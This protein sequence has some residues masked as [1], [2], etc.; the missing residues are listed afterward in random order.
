[1]APLTLAIM[2]PSRLT[3]HHAILSICMSGLC[4]VN[5]SLCTVVGK[6][7]VATREFNDIERMW[8]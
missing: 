4:L 5:C 7:I 6:S 3:H 8:C 1:M 2:V